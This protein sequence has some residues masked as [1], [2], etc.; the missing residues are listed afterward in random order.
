MVLPRLGS[1][2][3]AKRFTHSSSRSA[4]YLLFPLQLQ[5]LLNREENVKVLDATWFMPN[6]P[7]N[8]REEFLAKH[9]PKAQFLDLDAVASPHPLG[10]KH[11]LPSEA[12]F[13]TACESFGIRANTHVVIY[14]THG[15]FS[16]P[17]A[18]YMFR[19]FGHS[20]S[21]ILNGG[22]PFWEVEGLST[23]SGQ[24]QQP[25]TTHYS[26]PSLDTSSVRS[27]EQVVENAEHDPSS[28][29]AEV[30]LDARSRGRYLGT[31]P[32]P[33]P[34]LSS[35]HI[36]NSIALPFHVFLQTHEGPTS[37]T[38]VRSTADI[39][40]AL[41]EAVGSSQAES[42]INGQKS[43]VTTCGSG[44]TAGVL[45]LG[46]KLLGAPKVGLYDESWTGYALRPTSKIVK[47]R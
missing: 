39:R 35:G 47:D 28:Q 37:Y 22:L 30:V 7:R 33:R 27:Y 45:W 38:T 32:E 8:G 14:D 43:V 5:E 21:S 24:E 10:L 6:S 34:G 1:L 4:P 25:H 42:I 23:E 13:A 2:H 19:S 9:I 40:R 36:P 15:V 44:M 16:S 3:L 46:L 12:T 17:R 11:M 26:K 31:D 41:N 29:H 18:L 20:N